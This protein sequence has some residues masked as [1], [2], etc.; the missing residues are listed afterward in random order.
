MQWK[1]ELNDRK[2]RTFMYIEAEVKSSGGNDVRGAPF[3]SENKF[4]SCYPPLRG[5][6]F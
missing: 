1:E 4:L 3:F 6:E 5:A 2:K